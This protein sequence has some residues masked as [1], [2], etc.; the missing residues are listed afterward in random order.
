MLSFSEID[1]FDRNGLFDEMEFSYL[2][3]SENVDQ[4][5][6]HLNLHNQEV[7]ASEISEIGYQNGL[8]DEMDISYFGENEIVEQTELHLNLHS[9]EV[10][11]FPDDELF[12][13]YEAECDD[14]FMFNGLADTDSHEDKEEN[15]TMA[16]EL[17]IMMVTF[18]ISHRLM[19]HILDLLIK[20]NV[21]DVP[22]NVYQLKKSCR[23]PPPAFET[24]TKG[25][26]SYI[27][28]KDNLRYLIE[29]GTLLG[30]NCLNAVINIDGLP[31]FRSSSLCTW[32][33]LL[34][35]PDLKLQYPLPIGF[36]CGFGKPDLSIIT[37]KLCEELSE[38]IKN[39]FIH[40][41]VSIAIRKV[42]FVCDAPARAFLQCIKY[43]NARLGCP[44]CVV[45]GNRIDNR[46]VFLGFD[47]ELRSDSRYSNFQ[48]NNQVILS[49]LC[50]IPGFGL[51]TNFPI[52]YQHLIC[53][54]IMRRLC[55]FYFTSVKD[56]HLS[57]KL[58]ATQIQQASD[59]VL[60]IRQHI[61]SEFCRNIRV[62]SELAHL[63][64]LNSASYYCTWGH[65]YF[66]NF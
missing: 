46:T 19:Q 66:E 33:I 31:L 35:L 51:A 52:D 29:K 17:L 40:Q 7:D 61:P 54:G 23:I 36:Y 27:S 24:L 1:Q 64:L 20:F 45:S 11:A 37:S 25:H 28:I 34:S 63:R 49:P 22:R 13:D 43:H 42:L 30:K 2:G 6:L 32:P 5:E 26:F 55:F 57:C 62:F 38:L 41:N 3:E 9:P 4:A 50:K 16:E 58:S 53:L 65:T 59:I 60:R 56:F 44:Y 10:D 18:C 21:P 14:D 47:H 8:F 15:L 39:D 12:C 48:E